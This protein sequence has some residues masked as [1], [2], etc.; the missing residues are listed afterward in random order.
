MRININNSEDLKNEI[1]R[2]SRLK[3]EQEEYLSDQ[4]VL[5]RNKIETPSRVLGAVASNIPGIGLVKGLFSGIGAVAKKSDHESG[6]KDW[7]TRIFQVG[8]PLVLNK[9]LLKN[10]GWLKKSLVLLASEGA[11]SNINQD[12]VSSVITK[13]ANFIRPKKKKSHRDIESLEEE[14]DTVNFGIP[15]DSETY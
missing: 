5:L 9:T 8:V 12:K 6:S 3:I 11:A 2:L 4:Y 7:L 10:S 15:P 1:S 14:Q 13:V